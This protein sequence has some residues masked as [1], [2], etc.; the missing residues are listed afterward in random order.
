MLPILAMFETWRG[1]L[2]FI[3]P[4][5]PAAFARSAAPTASSQTFSATVMCADCF[6]RNLEGRQHESRPPTLHLRAPLEGRRAC[7]ARVHC[8]ARCLLDDSHH[9]THTSRVRAGG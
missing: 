2:A 6:P 4:L 5:L 7:S 9:R 3:R 1:A 8:I